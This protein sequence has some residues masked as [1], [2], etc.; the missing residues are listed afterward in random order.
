MDVS[1]VIKNAVFYGIATASLAGIY[2]MVIYFIG[3]SVSYAIGTEYQAII[4]GVIFIAFA[5]MLQSTKDKFQEL[6]TKQF[7]P[8]QFAFQKILLKFSNDIPSVVGLDNILKSTRNIFVESLKIKKFGIFLSKDHQPVYTLVRS[9]GFDGPLSTINDKQHLLRERINTKKNL[10]QLPVIEKE[11]FKD[12]FPDQVEYLNKEHVYTLIPLIIKSE[13][14]GFFLFGLK[15]SGARFADK[16]LELLV[17]TSN[18]IAVSIEN[19]RLYA[20]E[21]E[22][23]KIEQELEN[24]RKIQES[25]LPR[26]IPQFSQLEICGTMIPAMQVGGD[27]Y[28]VIKVSPAKVFIIVGDVSGKGL[29]ASFYM[30]KLQTM[31]KLFC[32]ENTTP[33]QV[34]MDINKRIY[35]SIEKNWFITVSIGLF[36]L[37]T[38]TMKYCR[39]GHSPL[40]TV[41]G[42]TIKEYQPKGIGVGLEKGEI[43]DSVIEEIEIKMNPDENYIFYSDGL[44]ESMDGNSDLY[45]MEK[46]E[47][48]LIKNSANP[49]SEILQNTLNDVKI[50]RGETPPNDDITLVIVKYKL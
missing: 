47:N 28:D 18:Q 31:I 10:N 26:I 40:V 29:S 36:D 1:H 16:D 49:C 46:L 22:K 2:F 4:A 50:F 9:Y 45:G 41:N 15:H 25:L 12:V 20:S 19:A 6:I 17:A 35:E 14:I 11:E 13:V 21:A 3:Q 30:S 39:A 5:L 42:Q 44:S 34:L 37:E 32:T 8:E 38:N 43:F 24:A 48:I 33:K 7:Y 23:M 27:Y